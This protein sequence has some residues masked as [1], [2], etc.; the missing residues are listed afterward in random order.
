MLTKPRRPFS[1]RPQHT[2]APVD[3]SAHA[4]FLPAATE[5]AP[6]SGPCTVSDAMS[7]NRTSPAKASKT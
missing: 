4:W 7:R 5:I 3:S 1:C 6:E 2:T